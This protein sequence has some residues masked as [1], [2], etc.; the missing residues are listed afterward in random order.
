MR[1]RDGELSMLFKRLYEDHV[2][3]RITAGQFQMLSADYNAEQKMLQEAIPEKEDRLEKLKASAANVEAFIEK[4]KRFTTIDEL[5]PEL[6]R[7]FIQRIEIGER[8]VKYSRSAAQS[9]RIIYRDIGNL[10]S[11]MEPGERQ[12]QM[13]TLPSMEDCLKLLA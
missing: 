12:P 7:L 8:S 6:A 1:K 9:V 2:L 3:Q 13:A 10:D 11:P 4:A 5:T